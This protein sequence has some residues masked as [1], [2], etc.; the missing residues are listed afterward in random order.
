MATEERV[1]SKL[2]N[3]GVL[4]TRLRQSLWDICTASKIVARNV[5]AQLLG[6]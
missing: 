3:N 2:S 6:C 4:K 5:L 1:L